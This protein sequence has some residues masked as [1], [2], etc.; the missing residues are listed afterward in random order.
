MLFFTKFSFWK[1]FEEFQK[2]ISL[3]INILKNVLEN[4][5]KG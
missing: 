3:E 4:F 2:I 5:H 1:T